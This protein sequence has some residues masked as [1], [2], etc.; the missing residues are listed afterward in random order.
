MQVTDNLMESSQ[1]QEKYKCFAVKKDEVEQTQCSKGN[2]MS[3][4]IQLNREEKKNSG[5]TKHSSKNIHKMNQFHT[6][7]WKVSVLLRML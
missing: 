3:T 5:K 7:F 4:Q 2:S 1:N 6:I